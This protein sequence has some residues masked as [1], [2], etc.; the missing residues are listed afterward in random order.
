MD[1]NIGLDFYEPIEFEFDGEWVY[2]LM[3]SSDY[4]R[5]KVG[6]TRNNPMARMVSLRTG[7]PGIG[8]Q[9]AYYIPKSIGKARD[10]EQ[11]MHSKLGERIE[12][13]EGGKSEWF[14][15]DPRDA[16][17]KLE[18]VFKELSI[19]ITDDLENSE[20]KVVRFWEE[21]ILTLFGPVA[22]VDEHGIPWDDLN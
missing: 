16:Y 6:H 15:G 9:V 12:F 1:K 7:D 2:V 10:I 5:Y 14:H 17:W 19:E 18:L 22:N 11:K 3:T 20:G 13:H 8:F 4:E 21:G